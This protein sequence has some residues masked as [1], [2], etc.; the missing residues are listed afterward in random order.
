[1]RTDTLLGRELEDPE[2]RRAYQQEKLIADATDLICA[3]M[4]E[5]EISRSTFAGWLGRTRGFVTQILSGSRNLTLRTLADSMTA[6]GYEIA[7]SRKRLFVNDTELWRTRLDRVIPIHNRPSPP[8]P[9]SPRRRQRAVR[10]SLP[11]PARWRLHDRQKNR[12]GASR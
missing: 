2:F 5:R 8:L 4:R 10:H 9:P 11:E 6:L 1:M 3:A 7:L 12:H